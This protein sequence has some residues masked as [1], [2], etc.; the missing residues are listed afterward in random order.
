MRAFFLLLFFCSSAF[1]QTFP[2]RAI[3]LVV[4]FPPGVGGLAG[5]NAVAKAPADVRGGTPEA[6]GAE[7][8]DDHARYG[9]I[10]QEFGIRAD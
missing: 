6:L 4:P 1:A 3:T 8:R 9:R 10:V 7:M 2:T 5:A